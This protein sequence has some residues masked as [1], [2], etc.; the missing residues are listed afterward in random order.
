MTNF[1]SKEAMKIAGCTYRQLDFWARQE[2]VTPSITP[3]L[4]SGTHRE[5]SFTDVIKLC[6]LTKTSSLGI[7]LN[8]FAKSLN[9]NSDVLSENDSELL[10]LTDG[11]RQVELMRVQDAFSL[12]V[13]GGNIIVF[14]NLLAIRKE[15]NE[16][17]AKMPPREIRGRKSGISKIK[18]VV[19]H[20]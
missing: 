3:A 7:N 17:I 16:L 2:Y 18:K 11:G 9:E 13:A 5:Y 20:A 1:T 8:N 6:I 12:I 19:N 14:L 15:I 10:A 4:G